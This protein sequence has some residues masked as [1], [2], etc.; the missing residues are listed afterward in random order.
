ML[1][2]KNIYLRCVMESD[3]SDLHAYFSSIQMKGE[4]LSSELLSLHQFRNQFIET[5][6]WT[7]EKGMLVLLHEEE[8]IGAIWFEKQN[9]FDCLDLHRSSFSVF[10]LFIRYEKNR[11]VA[12]ICSRLQQIGNS[13]CAKMSIPI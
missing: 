6:F 2:S 9:F 8:M 5:G 13:P 11:K 3:L 1:R 12:N 4:Y 10:P 7:E